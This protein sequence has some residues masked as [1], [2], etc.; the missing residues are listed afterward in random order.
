MARVDLPPYLTVK[1]VAGCGV[2][3]V[4]LELAQCAYTASKEAIAG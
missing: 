2:T 1:K 3:A 4:I